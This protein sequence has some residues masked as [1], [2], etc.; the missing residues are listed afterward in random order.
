[1]K[2]KVT[3]DTLAKVMTALV[4]AVLISIAYYM[5]RDVGNNEI[6]VIAPVVVLGFFILSL[7]SAWA[8][9]PTSYEVNENGI[10]IHRPI[11]ALTITKDQIVNI[12]PIDAAKLRFGMRLF[13]SGGFFGY[14]GLYSSNSIGRYIRYTGHS[15]NLIM[16]ETEKRRYVIGPDTE[17]F[18]KAVLALG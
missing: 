14:F 8:F 6:P 12:E 4:F 9:H 5:M 7:G 10:L 17:T 15:K 16:I 1:M 13:A 18:A 3:L 11:G 2:E